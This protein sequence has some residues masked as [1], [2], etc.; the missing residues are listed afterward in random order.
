MWQKRKSSIGSF[1]L[2][3]LVS[4]PLLYK[5]LKKFLY[6]RGYDLT[7]IPLATPGP[8]DMKN[9]GAVLEQTLTVTAMEIEQSVRGPTKA[10]GFRPPPQTCVERVEVRL[11]FNGDG[12]ATIQL[13][14]VMR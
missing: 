5:P 10:I 7:L 6:E 9:S 14:T 2:K 13:R 8:V 3:D 1:A 4:N 12:S 11:N